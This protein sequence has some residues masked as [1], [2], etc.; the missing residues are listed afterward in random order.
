MPLKIS[1]AFAIA[2]AAN[3]VG[4]FVVFAIVYHYE[5]ANG[6]NEHLH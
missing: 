3:V 4:A 5:K 2:V 1:H 6:K